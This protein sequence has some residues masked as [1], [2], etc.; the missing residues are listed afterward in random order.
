M[1]VPHHALQKNESQ[2]FISKHKTKKTSVVRQRVILKTNVSLA[3][4]VDVETTDGPRAT[5]SDIQPRPWHRR[6]GIVKP[7]QTA[8]RKKNM[9][10]SC[11]C[12]QGYMFHVSQQANKRPHPWAAH[13]SKPLFCSP[14]ST[15]SFICDSSTPIHSA[16]GTKKFS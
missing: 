15:D 5:A 10:N 8:R 1:H 6:N 4:M 3:D 2:S 11:C 16:I 12:M 13:V 9:T 14:R 7:C